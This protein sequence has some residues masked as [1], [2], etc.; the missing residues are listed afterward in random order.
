MKASGWLTPQIAQTSQAV[1]HACIFQWH[2]QL[3]PFL[4][5]L[6]TPAGAQPTPVYE[7]PPTA[8]VMPYCEPKRLRRF[9]CTCPN[10]INGIN[11]RSNIKKK[12][13]NCPYPGCKKVY[14]PST[15]SSSLAQRWTAVCLLLEILQQT[16]H[17]FR[18]VTKNLKTHTRERHYVCNECKKRF[19]RSDHL[20]KHLKTHKRK[21]E[22]K[23]NV[24]TSC[25]LLDIQSHACSQLIQPV[26]C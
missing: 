12:Q 21:Q 6:S 26:M 16:F 17:P 14:K 8:F 11:S 25:F 3:P 1:F 15:C 24:W 20:N 2:R 9:A 18:Q 19:M 7:P 23:K 4:S 13:H 5:P 10:C 22:K